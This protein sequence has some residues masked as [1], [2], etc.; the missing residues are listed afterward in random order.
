MKLLVVTQVVDSTDTYLGFFHEWIRELAARFEQVEVVCLYEGAHTLPAN[1]RVYSL[2][3]EKGNG[4]TLLYAVRFLTVAWRLRRDYDKVFVHMNEEYLLVAGLL[5]KM[6]RKPVY[7][8]RNHYAGSWKTRIAAALS[9]KVFY[10]SMHSYTARFRNA[11]Q[12]PV[13]VDLQRFQNQPAQDRRT[14]LFFGR[15]SPSK[16]PH[17][18]IEALGILKNRGATFSASFYGSALPADELY[19]AEIVERMRELDLSDRV[20]FHEGVSHAVAPDIFAGHE[21]YVNL[22]ESGML[23]KTLFEAAASGCRVL[24]RSEDWKRIAGDT[25]YLTDAEPAGIAMRL[26]SALSADSSTNLSMTLE[27]H[28]LPALAHQLAE[29]MSGRLGISDEDATHPTEGGI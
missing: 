8:W 11:V 14:F 17:V 4:S 1:V 26:E 3:K 28:A 10:T 13:G 16:R 25:Y 2:G 7:L 9:T 18:L 27:R 20:L 15:F 19:R 23:D 6:L 5:W 12:M 22:A 21:T 29:E 24:A